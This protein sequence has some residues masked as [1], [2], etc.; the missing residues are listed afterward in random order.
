MKKKV[1]VDLLSSLP[2]IVPVGLILLMRPILAPCTVENNCQGSLIMTASCLGAIIAF[3]LYKINRKQDSTI[4]NPS[5]EKRLYWGT[6]G[7]IGLLTV[8]AV[9][10]LFRNYF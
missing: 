9:E 3:S 5:Q 1:L 4:F 7:W 6:W 10:M 2:L 8:V